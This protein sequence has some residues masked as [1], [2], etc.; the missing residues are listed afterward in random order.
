MEELVLNDFSFE[1]WVKC[2]FAPGMAEN[3]WCEVSPRL[4][5]N[6]LTKFFSN[7]AVILEIYSDEEVSVGLR[8]LAS[9]NYSDTMY[10]LEDETIPWP[11]RQACIQSMY[12]LFEQLFA[13][14]CT[15]QLSFPPERFLP[16]PLNQVSRYWF[17]YLPLH[18]WSGLPLNV[19][20]EFLD[21]FRRVLTIDSDIC[22]EGALSGLGSW[23]LYHPEKVELILDEFLVNNPNLD[24]QLRE[25]VA[26]ARESMNTL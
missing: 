21:V 24:P 1:D 14:R 19:N 10:C 11:E 5:V 15:P 3:K 23:N 26:L 13:C 17:D 12:A 9:N 18:G 20:M 4:T 22:N 2:V 25:H 7:A 6:Y 8:Y 16:N